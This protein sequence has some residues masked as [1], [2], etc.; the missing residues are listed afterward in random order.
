MTPTNKIPSFAQDI[1]PMFREDDREAMDYA[2]DLWNYN[3]V[4]THAQSILERIE[5]GTMP[6]DLAWTEE[7]ITLLRSWINTGMAA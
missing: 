4:R 5:D 2:F 6:C 1:Q 3:D 7:Q